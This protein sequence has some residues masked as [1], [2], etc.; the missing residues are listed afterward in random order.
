MLLIAEQNLVEALGR[1]DCLVSSMRS[2]KV[3][4]TSYN[5]PCYVRLVILSSAATLGAAVD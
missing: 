3:V 2:C 5:A 4:D 1:D